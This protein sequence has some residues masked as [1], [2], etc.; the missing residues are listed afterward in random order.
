MEEARGLLF[1]SADVLDDFERLFP[2]WLIET[3]K[4]Y[5]LINVRSPGIKARSNKLTAAVAS[6]RN[7]SRAVENSSNFCGPNTKDDLARAL[8]EFYR[9]LR[10]T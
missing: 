1:W 10:L 6:E 3:G 7:Q 8:K 9:E 5:R 4:L 2:N